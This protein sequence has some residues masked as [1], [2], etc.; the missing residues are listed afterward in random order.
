MRL[1]NE[2]QGKIRPHIL[3]SDHGFYGKVN[4]FDIETNETIII[5]LVFLEIKYKLINIFKFST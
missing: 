2:S 5:L 3:G 1:V 4:N